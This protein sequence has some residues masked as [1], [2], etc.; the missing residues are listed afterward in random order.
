[1]MKN[2]SLPGFLL[3][4][5]VQLFTFVFGIAPLKAQVAEDVRPDDRIYQGIRFIILQDYDKAI[6]IFDSLSAISAKDPGPYFYH[7]AA[8]Q[9]R[10]MDLELY[11]GSDAFLELI[12]KVMKLSEEQINLRPDQPDGYF[13]KGS[14]HG[15]RAYHHAKQKEYLRGFMDAVT[16][17]ENLERALAI[18]SSYYDAYL[19]IGTYKYWRGRLT[20]KVDWL[21]FVEDEG[22]LGLEMIRKSARNGRYSREAAINALIW[23]QID[24]QEFIEAIALCKQ[25]LQRFPGSR[26]FLWPLAEAYYKSGKFPES[27]GVFA[28]LQH[29]YTTEANNNHYNEFLC[30]YKMVRSYA[31]LGKMADV[32]KEAAALMAMPLSSA[33]EKKLKGKI[34]EIKSYNKD[35]R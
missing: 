14:A 31:K 22:A 16:A 33:I 13:Y 24:R 6:A 27:I 28:K 32:C 1:M 5:L 4:L 21:P 19:G 3:C 7:A 23:I 20:N 18:D 17:T 30:G 29:S 25:E 15:Y 8:L 11:D 35:C 2:A 10:M 26:F 34:S 9:S 12:E